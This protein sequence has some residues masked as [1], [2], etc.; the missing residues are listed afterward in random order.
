MVSDYSIIKNSKNTHIFFFALTPH[1]SIL[2]VLNSLLNFEIRIH[3]EGSHIG[4]GFINDFATHNEDRRVILQ[5]LELQRTS[6]PI[7]VHE[8]HI[9]RSQL[10]VIY[11]NGAA[12]HKDN[13]RV[14]FGIWDFNNRPLLGERNVPHINGRVC[15]GRPLGVSYRSG[16][17]AGCRAA[18]S[19]QFNDR[20]LGIRDGLIAGFNH[21]VFLGEIH[22]QL[23]HF[24]GTSSL[25]EFL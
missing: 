8:C 9:L 7:I 14:I 17:D 23:R 5:D 24:K 13:T 19:C 1:A 4:N 12:S 21:F 22:P 18:F 2:K 16:N 6:I 3:D 10:F 15:F 20:N 11:S 25:T